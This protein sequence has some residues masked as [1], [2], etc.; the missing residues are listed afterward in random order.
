MTLRKRSHT[1]V[2][3]WIKLQHL[4]VELWTPDGL[5]TVASSVGWPL[6]PNAIT[7]AGTRLDYARV[8]VLIDFSSTL[9][10]HLII[11]TPDEDG[12]EHPCRVD[13]EYEW[14]PKKCVDCRALG[15]SVTECPSRKKATRPPVIVFVQKPQPT[16]QTRVPVER[17]DPPT[18]QAVMRGPDRS[19]PMDDSACTG[20][21]IVVF[22]PFDA[23]SNLDDVVESE[24]GPNSSSPCDGLP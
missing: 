20:K 17:M 3:I 1:Q 6:Y 21:E 11:L 24:R 8:C 15:H 2:P 10:K 23:L 22:N 13:I 5:S 9:P 12:G 14:V 16:A 4:P 19:P 7:K 18:E